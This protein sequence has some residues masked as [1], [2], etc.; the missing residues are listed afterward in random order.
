[1]RISQALSIIN[2]LFLSTNVVAF[3][4]SPYVDLTLNVHWDHQTQQLEVMDLVTP[5]LQHGIK[6]YHLCFITDSGQCQPAWGSQQTYSVASGWGSQQANLLAQHGIQTNVSFG[7]A[8]GTD[9][10]SSCNQT[11][12]VSIFKQVISTYHAGALDF[13]IENGTADVAKLVS[14]LKTVQKTHPKVKL[15]FTLPVMPEGLTFQGKEIVKAA[16]QGDLKFNVNIMAMDYGPA[17]SGDM[18][19]Y[20]TQAAFNLHQFLKELYPNR[21]ATELWQQVEITPMIGVN[22]V[23]TGQFTL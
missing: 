19:Q 7:G 1:M 22:E 4:F 6:A 16:Q 17:Y 15:S 3:S 5:A 23:A 10:S 18:G 8:N 2:G 21:S 11:Q 9:I 20:A 12:L 14:A 13:D